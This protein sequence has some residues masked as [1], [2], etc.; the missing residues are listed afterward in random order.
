MTELEEELWCL[1]LYSQPK[2]VSRAYPFLHMGEDQGPDLSW[3]LN[4]INLILKLLMAYFSSFI[5]A[6]M[7]HSFPTE[8][9]STIKF[10]LFSCFTSE[11][12]RN[13]GLHWVL[14]QAWYIWND[15]IIIWTCSWRSSTSRRMLE[16]NNFAHSTFRP[17]YG[18]KNNRCRFFF[19][20]C[21]YMINPTVTS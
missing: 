21:L 20:Y 6:T 5:W 3:K 11:N 2:Q 16:Q 15:I 4:H 10:V 7:V 12:L 8:C 14:I 9:H 17:F 13:H 1:S 18:I 19:N